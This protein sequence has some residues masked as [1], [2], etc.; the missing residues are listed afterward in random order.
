MLEM[1]LATTTTWN[2]RNRDLIVVGNLPAT[3]GRAHELGIDG[4]LRL[5]FVPV[6]V[7]ATHYT[8]GHAL[9]SDFEYR[10]TRVAASGEFGL[11][12]FATLIPQAAYGRLSNT[13][14]PQAAFYLGGAHSLRS[15]PSAARGGAGMILARLDL[16][17]TADILEVAH[18]PH[19]SSLPIQAGVFAGSGAVWG[20]DP[21]GGPPVS[22]T[23]WPRDGAWVHEAGFSLVYQPGIPD[24][25]TLVRLNYALPLG[26]QRESAHWTVSFSRA[27]D[28]VKPLG[29]D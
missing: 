28:L 18:L 7:Q 2:F 16:I 3:R 24:G 25:M 19:P 14:V 17:G 29:G 11:G 26:P 10:R 4:E 27:I 12:S 6:I 20:A 9:G 5:P 15:L 13:L 1:P 23:D 8:S 22:G 21:Y